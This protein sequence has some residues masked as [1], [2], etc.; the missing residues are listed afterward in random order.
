MKKLFIETLQTVLMWA[1][2][3]PV[4][5]AVCF[6]IRFVLLLTYA[7]TSSAS[8]AASITAVISVS[9]AGLALWVWA[10]FTSD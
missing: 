6:A 9:T 8:L 2:I 1:C 7:L 3:L 10:H 4:T 5:Y